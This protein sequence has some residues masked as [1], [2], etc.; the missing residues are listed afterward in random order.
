MD[1]MKT[2]KLLG[3]GQEVPAARDEEI[4]AAYQSLFGKP[5]QGSGTTNNWKIERVQ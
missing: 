4:R 1:R 5:G 2:R 3:K